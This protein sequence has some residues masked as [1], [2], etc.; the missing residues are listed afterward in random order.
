MANKVSPGL[1][2]GMVIG[3]LGLGAGTTW[4][5]TQ[6]THAAPTA[7]TKPTVPGQIVKLDGFTVNLADPE[8]SH[9]LRLTLALEVGHLPEGDKEKPEAAIPI[10]QIRDAILT[11]LTAAKADALL[12][13]EG[14]LQ[15]KKNLLSSLKSGVP[16]LD[17]RDIYFTEF[18]VQR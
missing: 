4:L 11:V 15:L 3:S 8:A 14:K 2:F 18:L 6:R 12:T 9:F 1:I 10:A 13:P 16:Q 5:I 7:A 17:V